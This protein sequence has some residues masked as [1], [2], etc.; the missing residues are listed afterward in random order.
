MLGLFKK[1][2]PIEKLSAERQRLLEQ[3]RKLSASNR[4]ASDEMYFK[5]DELDRQIA[6]LQN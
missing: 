4:K 3:A 2:S 6:Q 1:K 5:A